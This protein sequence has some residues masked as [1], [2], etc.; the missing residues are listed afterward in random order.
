V[1]PLKYLAVSVPVKTDL[2]VS[3]PLEG[4]PAAS[5]LLETDLAVSLPKTTEFGTCELPADEIRI[6]WYHFCL[7]AVNLALVNLYC[8][9]LIIYM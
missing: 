8:E 6:S 4:A 1:S 3:L 7:R 5:V 2:A 9:F